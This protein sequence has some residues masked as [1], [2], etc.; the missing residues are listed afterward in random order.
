MK[1]KFSAHT[2]LGSKI[3]SINSDLERIECSLRQ[4]Q[5]NQYHHQSNAFINISHLS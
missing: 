2:S 4:R 1:W 3:A 5:Q